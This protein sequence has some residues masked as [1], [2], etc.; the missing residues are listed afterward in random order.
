[1]KEYIER[2]KLIDDI[3]QALLVEPSEDFLLP[4]EKDIVR[5]IKSEPVADVVSKE[6]YNRLQEENTKL[7]NKVR[8]LKK[9]IRDM[10][11]DAS[12]DEDIRCRQVQG[13]W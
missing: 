5:M 4:P 8:S 7:K 2:E 9:K 6:E 12:W 13:M 3:L 1:M 11:S 10:K